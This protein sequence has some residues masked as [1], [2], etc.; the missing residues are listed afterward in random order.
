MC[1]QVLRCVAQV[2]T[3]R[4]RRCRAGSASAQGRTRDTIRGQTRS[5]MHPGRT[6]RRREPLGCCYVAPACTR[7]RTTVLA[8]VGIFPPGTCGIY[9][10]PNPLCIGLV[11]TSNT[12]DPRCGC[13][14]H[15]LRRKAP[16]CMCVCANM[17]ARPL[18]PGSHLDCT[19]CTQQHACCTCPQDNRHICGH[20]SRLALTL[21]T[22]LQRTLYATDTCERL[23]P[24]DTSLES[25]C[26]M[27]WNAFARCTFPRGNLR[28]CGRALRSAT[29]LHTFRERTVLATDKRASPYPVG[30]YHWRKHCTKLHWASAH[31]SQESMQYNKAVRGRVASGP[32]CTQCTDRAPGQ[33]GA[34]LLDMRCNEH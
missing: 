34:F 13:P 8:R 2:R 21:H 20:V 25:S 15:H 30:T 9:S 31:A 33:A 32:D 28:I 10:C 14:H 4:T 22:S 27:Q 17:L 11:H 3:Q 16:A 23:C 5:G 18:L 1:H 19:S 26:C 6:Y 7:C 24:A 29:M 12:F